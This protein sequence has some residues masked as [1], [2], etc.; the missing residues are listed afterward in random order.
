MAFLQAMGNNGGSGGAGG[1]A[2]GGGGGGQGGGGGILPPP[3][4]ATAAEAIQLALAN[5][6]NLAQTVFADAQTASENAETVLEA[7]ALALYDAVNPAEK[8]A[9][10][11]PAT[12]GL[13]M[14]VQGR[15][16]FNFA[17]SPFRAWVFGLAAA[18]ENHAA[19]KPAAVV[20]LE[21]VAVAARERD[22]LKA[23]QGMVDQLQALAQASA[24]AERENNR[25][26]RSANDI[27]Q[28]ARDSAQEAQDNLAAITA[29][30][31]P[32]DPHPVFVGGTLWYRHASYAIGFDPRILLTLDLFP[33]HWKNV[34]MFV[35]ELLRIT[36]ELSESVILDGRERRDTQ[37]TCRLALAGAVLSMYTDH[38][39]FVMEQEAREP[40]LA[41]QMGTMAA[42]LAAATGSS[43]ASQHARFSRELPFAR[44]SGALPSP[45]AFANA[46]ALLGAIGRHTAHAQRAVRAEPDNTI[47]AQA[48]A[49]MVRQ[50]DLLIT[51]ILA[52]GPTIQAGL[53]SSLAKAAA[54]ADGMRQIELALD[55]A[56]GPFRAKLR[57]LLVHGSARLAV[58]TMPADIGRGVILPGE[59]AK[60]QRTD[61]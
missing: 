60:R 56:L 57:R 59:A 44:F 36:E 6:K 17:S 28:G 53:P 2:S 43:A 9:E 41:E 47:R 51:Q 8:E 5:Q 54:T 24:F 22:R 38:E 52:F 4:P 42:T 61:G 18:T 34:S 48:A 46:T 58:D 35:K 32:V 13:P 30:G 33:D 23:A 26:L 55:V 20:V 14:T 3:P 7:A 40:T 37:A 50:Y 31:L 11:W 15:P 29:L 27:A 16:V 12:G 1:A 19:L 45:R 25:L 10:S 21:A 39:S 49:A